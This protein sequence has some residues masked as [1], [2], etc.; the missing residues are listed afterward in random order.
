MASS[1][2]I[3]LLTDYIKKISSD[4]FLNR[5]VILYEGEVNHEI[6]KSILYTLESYFE[7]ANISRQVQKK[8]FNVVVECIQNIEKHTLFLSSFDSFFAQKGSLMLL[9][10]KNF[11]EIYSGNWVNQ[12]QKAILIKK[13]NQIKDKS[14]EQLREVY[15]Q[16][17][18]SGTISSKGGAGLG[19]I[20]IA[21]KTNNN[22]E[23]YFFD[24]HSDLN[25]FINKIIINKY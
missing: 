1:V 18:V 21:R 10:N 23:F 14:K 11:I 5:M 24:T 4:F 20:D 2:E 16:Q 12:E 8:V 6:I 17:L 15:K 13:E 25:Y 22:I 9:E 7:K 3:L 19:F